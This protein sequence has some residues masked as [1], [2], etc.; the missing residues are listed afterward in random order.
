[1]AVT[2]TW[3]IGPLETAVSENGF[4]DVVKTVHWRLMGSDGVNNQELYGSVALDAPSSSTYT[5]FDSLSQ[6]EVLDWVKSKL[7]EEVLK[8]SLEDGLAALASP[9][10]VNRT[11]PW[12]PISDPIADAAPKVVKKKTTK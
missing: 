12:G 2:Y 9:A 3:S 6:A 7:D 8:K 5:S 11:P 10:V 4:N 1:M